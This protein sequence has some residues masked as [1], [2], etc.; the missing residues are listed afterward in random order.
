MRGWER[1]CAII[2]FVLLFSEVRVFK[3]IE[4]S[5]RRWH[6]LFK[7]FLALCWVSHFSWSFKILEKLNQLRW[8]YFESMKEL[9]VL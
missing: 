6:H 5:L 3:K 7:T 2:C 8:R 1:G 4:I 9:H